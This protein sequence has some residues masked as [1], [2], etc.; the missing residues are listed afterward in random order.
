[1]RLTL[2]I[3]LLTSLVSAASVTTDCIHNIRKKRLE[4]VALGRASSLGILVV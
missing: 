1:M 2:V 3:L 4:Y